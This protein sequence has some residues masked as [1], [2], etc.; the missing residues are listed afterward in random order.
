MSLAEKKIWYNIRKKEEKA[1]QCAQSLFVKSYDISSFVWLP[2]R[3]L[4]AIIVICVSLRWRLVRSLNKKTKTKIEQLVFDRKTSF[5]GVW[6][7]SISDIVLFSSR[8]IC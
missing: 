8:S 3:Q 7:L 5:T 6:L 1:F 2:N 4:W